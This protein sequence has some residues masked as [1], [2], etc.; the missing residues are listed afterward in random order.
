M[1][2][3]H[4]VLR[5]HCDGGVHHAGMDW[6]H[7]HLRES[8]PFRSVEQLLFRQRVFVRRRGL[9]GET[10]RVDR[11]TEHGHKSGRDFGRRF[12]VH[13]RGRRGD[14]AAVFLFPVNDRVPH[15]R[16]VTHFVR[17]V[18]FCIFPPYL[19]TMLYR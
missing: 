4:R 8:S 12:R 13:S 3:I 17:F 14:V 16:M 10:G 7:D 18:A 5:D 11:H 19:F 1:G 15:L 2:H 6:R 9:S